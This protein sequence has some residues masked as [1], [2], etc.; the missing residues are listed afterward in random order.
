MGRADDTASV[1]SR[2]RQHA[3]LVRL[4]SARALARHYHDEHGL[5]LMEAGAHRSASGRGEVE[6]QAGQVI[7]VNPGEIHD[8]RPV[9]ETGRRWSMVYFDA[10]F[11]ARIWSEISPAARAFEFL[12]PVDEDA[13]SARRVRRLLSRLVVDG[14]EALAVEELAPALL[15][16][17]GLEKTPPP[18]RGAPAGI[19]RSKALIE[20]DPTRALGLAE[21]AAEAGLSR[22]ETVRAFARAFG[23]TPYAYLIERRLLAARRLIVAGE[24]LAGAA[25][26]A[27][28]ADQSHMH[29]LFVRRYGFTPGA[30]ARA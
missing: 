24:P 27:G 5:G 28:F 26:A 17:L 10:D 16:G 12:R 23:M 11:L 20:A 2:P 22:F 19:R 15:A 29:R 6:A 14:E 9:G 8:G 7:T 18:G 4:S 25:T 30:L 13:A 21:L 3:L 1:V